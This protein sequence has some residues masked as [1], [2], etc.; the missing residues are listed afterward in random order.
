MSSD[1]QLSLILLLVMGGASVVATVAGGIFG[2]RKE[3]CQAAFT[4]WTPCTDECDV[5]P[6]RSRKYVITA[7]A[8]A[9]PYIDGYTET[10]SCG[11]VQPC[12]ELERD[13]EP[14]GTCSTIGL[15][16]FTRTLKENKDGACADF[17]TEQYVP[18]CREEGDWQLDGT[19]GQY[20]PGKQRYK[21]TTVGCPVEKDYRYEECAPCV[22]DWSN[23]LP[24]EC[25]DSCGY[26]G[27][28]F[29]KTWNVI[30]EKIGTG[31]CAHPDGYQESLSC[32]STD[33]CPCPG[34]FEDFPSC[35]T[36]C[37]QPQTTVYRFWQP[38]TKEA[39]TDYQSCPT[40]ESKT[41]PATPSC[42]ARTEWTPS[43]Q[44]TELGQ[45]QVRTVTDCTEDTDEVRYM[46]CCEYTPWTP[47]GQ[48]TA[49]GTQKQVRQEGDDSGLTVI[50]DGSIMVPAPCAKEE[51]L[52]LEQ[53]VPCCGYTTWTPSGQ[54]TADQQK[55]VRAVGTTVEG[56][57][58]EETSELEKYAP[59]CGYSEWEPSEGCTPDGQK[60]VRTVDTTVPGCAP[61]ATTELE[62]FMDCCGY[63]EWTPSGQCSSDN[64]QTQVRAVGT[65]VPGC[66]PEATSVLEK[67]V[68]CCGYTTWTPSGQCTADQ[69]KQV[70]AVGTT[71][72]GCA[73]EATTE[74][75]KFMACCGYSEWEPSGTCEE[76]VGGTDAAQ[77]KVRSV[78]ASTTER[79]CAPEQTTQAL[80]GADPCCIQKDD[81]A[82]VGV[83]TDKKQTEQQTV[84]GSACTPGLDTKT[85]P[86]APCEGD[87]LS[88]PCPTGCGFAAQTDIAKTWTTTEPV[89]GTGTC[90]TD[91]NAPAA[92]T[93]TCPATTPCVCEGEYDID[94]PTGCGYGGG[95][96]RTFTQ[97]GEISGRIYGTCPA[98]QTC[99]ATPACPSS[100]GVVTGAVGAGIAGAG[101]LFCSKY[102]ELCFGG[103]PPMTGEDAQNLLDDTD[104]NCIGYWDKE[105]PSECP[106]C[107]SSAKTYTATY[108]H[109][110]KQKGGGAACE[111]HDGAQ[112]T[113]TCPATNPCCTY[114]EWKPLVTGSAACVGGQISVSRTK[115][116][117]PCAFNP[118]VD[119]RLEKSVPCTNCG[120]SWD[121]SFPTCPTCDYNGGTVYKEW[122]QT[123][124]V[125]QDSNGYGEACPT[126]ADRPSKYCPATPPC[127]TDCE[128]GGWD[129]YK[130]GFPSCPTACG[131]GAVTYT[132]NWVGATPATNGGDPCPPSETKT[133]PATPDCP[134]C[135]YTEWEYSGSCD[136][137]KKKQAFTRTK[138]NA[139]CKPESPD[140]TKS[141]SCSNCE[142]GW[143]DD[144]TYTYTY[145]NPR[146]EC[147]S[148]TNTCYCSYYKNQYYG[149]ITPA[150]NTSC[151]AAGVGYE[152]VYAGEW[153]C[154]MENCPDKCYR[155]SPGAR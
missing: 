117:T 137:I 58:P 55:Q 80:V 63:T 84:I 83:C 140:T 133:C 18:C 5:E 17:P 61:E 3:G 138:T 33:P 149:V 145:N 79:P 22:A 136:T 154:G 29:T 109:Y 96:T 44:C 110:I 141:E 71:L 52:V 119:N 36:E 68:P 72:P 82:P 92:P 41:C 111:Y 70:R 48:C 144:G 108:S 107:G 93:Y 25:R 122:N 104:V 124:G 128:G 121:A 8:A 2:T 95:D 116:N 12:C 21:Q 106:S 28:T 134:P 102:P 130:N 135:Q 152:S 118:S 87:W 150:S 15:Q 143:I 74:L 37:G 125:Y 76:T 67:D 100:V 127:A 99:D 66:V 11:P 60:Q 151:P 9:C 23:D 75:E 132:R 31:T 142:Y 113:K 131:S 88:S 98:N 1:E 34:G 14:Q 38:G 105:L 120:G 115:T 59:C 153:N 146:T 51:T 103:N 78:I 35:P 19:C 91:A 24:S 53:D 16:K 32:P 73:P 46:P 114:S 45:K 77:A 85:V 90:P 54:C 148:Y 101:G 123:P 20:E 26:R 47:S 56:C 89:V 27:E 13:W 147:G 7:G 57:G 112:A 155:A 62:K 42:C 4:P 64:K 40:S 129:N 69:Q 97:T 126:D 50:S 10:E 6:T 39:D 139:P 94:C 86:C 30:T 43:G 81:W 65:T 49:E